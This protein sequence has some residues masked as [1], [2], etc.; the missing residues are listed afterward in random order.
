MS[1]SGRCQPN[2]LRHQSFVAKN[3]QTKT[4]Y[5]SYVRPIATVRLLCKTS[6]YMILGQIET[7]L[8]A[9]QPEE[10]HGFRQKYGFLRTPVGGKLAHGQGH[11]I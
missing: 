5:L 4:S 11:R 1:G 10:Q 8:D 9:M 3:N 2:G 6:A 7:T